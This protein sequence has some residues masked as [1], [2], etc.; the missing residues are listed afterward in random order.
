[1]Y[2]LL[3]SGLLLFDCFPFPVLNSIVDCPVE[4]EVGGGN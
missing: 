2:I 3:R 1:M 4:N